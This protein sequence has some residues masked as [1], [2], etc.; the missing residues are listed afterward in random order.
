MF[1]SIQTGAFANA[2]GPRTITASDCTLQSVRVAVSTAQE[3]DTVLL[4]PGRAV[5]T[6]GLVVDKG[7]NVFGSGADRTIITDG[8]MT[9]PSGHSLIAF[10]G[11]FTNRVRISGFTVAADAGK[12]V[13]V[14]SLGNPTNVFRIDNIVITNLSKAGVQLVGWNIGVID[15][16]KFYARRLSNPTGVRIFGEGAYSWDVRP[17]SWGDINKVYVEDCAF[18]WDVNANGAVD[19]YNAARWA[20]RHNMV[21]NVN[22]GN[23]GTDSSGSL[24][25]THSFEVYNNHFANT[26]TRTMLFFAFRG[27]T[28]VIYNNSLTGQFIY[29]TIGLFNY[30]ASGTN[31]YKGVIPCC[32]PFG[33]INGRNPFD[34][35][36][37]EFGWPPF[38]SIGRTS[39]TIYVTN[40]L[41]TNGL[42]TAYT[43]QGSQPLYQWDNHLN[44]GRGVEKLVV[45]VGNVY[46]NTG[47]YAG[48]PPATKL[49]QKNRDYYDNV[50]MPG[51][52]SFTYPH[53]FVTA[54][55]V[56]QPPSRP[57]RPR[58]AE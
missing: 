47:V 16:C 41:A 2:V 14:L 22:V 53:P 28:G 26:T 48:I 9:A 29:P 24:R 37:D 58:S 13:A 36:I 20:F 30:R 5:W 3:G 23:H 6:E 34:G 39:P 51:Y 38:D 27:G 57:A 40:K 43:I 21:T 17:P 11:N 56:S 25:S 55:E 49:I 1:V 33:P 44:R 50:A 54:D 32:E 15:H 7:I 19:S 46:T 12:V 4:P 35:N 52:T 10:G 18:S 8:W 31:I 45:D 42:A